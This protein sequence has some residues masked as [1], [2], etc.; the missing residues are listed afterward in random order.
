M[1]IKRRFCPS[2]LTTFQLSPTLCRG[3]QMRVVRVA[4]PYSWSHLLRL[5]I[6]VSHL[7]P[8]RAGSISSQASQFLS[9]EQESAPGRSAIS[10]QSHPPKRSA[11][12]G[13]KTPQFSTGALTSLTSCRLFTL[14]P[15]YR[16]QNR[17][18]RRPGRRRRR[19][20]VD[21]RSSRR[22]MASQPRGA[23]RPTS[24]RPRL[25]RSCRKRRRSSER[26]WKPKTRMERRRR[27][28]CYKSR[29]RRQDPW[30]CWLNTGIS[31][32]Q[33]AAAPARLG[34]RNGTL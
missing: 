1:H 31:R 17:W 32:R 24:P 25:S 27:V 34:S 33:F 22:H 6:H 28:K 7:R 13:P 18:M 3:Q 30:R 9:V 8:L 23:P 10:C 4:V 21:R 15:P 2:C 14:K 5:N 12:P 20:A 19:R 29:I 11:A 16:R 26:R